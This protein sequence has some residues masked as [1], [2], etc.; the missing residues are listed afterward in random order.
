VLSWVLGGVQTP[1]WAV[2]GLF[3]LISAACF[4]LT[5]LLAGGLDVLGLGETMAVGF[6]L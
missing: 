2:L 4:G 1:T 3:A 5:M 6:G